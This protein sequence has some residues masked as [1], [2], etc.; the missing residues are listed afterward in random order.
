MCVGCDVAVC[1]CV[2][3]SGGWGMDAVSGIMG[4][5]LVV[6]HRF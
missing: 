1:V 3:T 6:W 2:V 5:V 4:V